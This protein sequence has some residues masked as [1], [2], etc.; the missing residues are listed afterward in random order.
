VRR[1]G[2]RAILVCVCF[3]RF[4]FPLSGAADAIR[5]NESDN[6]PQGPRDDRGG[7]SAVD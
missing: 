2:V 7:R 6:N 4:V 3:P 5:R 1:I